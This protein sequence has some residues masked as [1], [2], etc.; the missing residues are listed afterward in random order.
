MPSSQ[1]PT[2]DE[3]MQ[4]TITEG[5]IQVFGPGNVGISLTAGAARRSAERLLAA[6]NKL[7]PDYPSPL[8]EPRA[9]YDKGLG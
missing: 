3:A 8:A 1:D 6:A 4:V 9:I 7:E 5:A 2:F